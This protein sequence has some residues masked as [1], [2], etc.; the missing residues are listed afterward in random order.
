M[1]VRVSSIVKNEKDEFNSTMPFANEEG[2]SK[3][4]REYT[5]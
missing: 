4:L 2:A 1:N 3:S 5:R